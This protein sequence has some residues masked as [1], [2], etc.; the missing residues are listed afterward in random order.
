MNLGAL[1]ATQHGGIAQEYGVQ[2]QIMMECIVICTR[3][4]SYQGYPTIKYFGP[5]SS[6][7][8]EY[9]GGRTAGDIVK[10]AEEK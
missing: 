10:W 7:A 6:D 2:V 3:M 8:E 9:S 1:D 5:G 4:L